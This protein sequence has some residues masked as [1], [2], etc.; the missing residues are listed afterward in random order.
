[1]MWNAETP[2]G[3]IYWLSDSDNPLVGSAIVA[4]RIRDAE[5]T[6]VQIAWPADPVQ[7]KITNPGDVRLVLDVMYGED[8]VYSDNAPEPTEF[9]APIDEKLVY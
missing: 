6:G 5:A 3:K 8:V 2:Q 7:I 9:F 1:M 4:F